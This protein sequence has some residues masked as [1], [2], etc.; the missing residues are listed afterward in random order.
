MTFA[1][2]LQRYLSLGID[3]QHRRL[4]GYR[5]FESGEVYKH[6]WEEIVKWRQDIPA[7]LKAVD[8][9]VPATWGTAPALF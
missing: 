8:A 5:A 9:V 4:E 6:Y 2:E 3:L 1:E 7:K